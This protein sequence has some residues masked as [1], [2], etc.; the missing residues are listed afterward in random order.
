MRGDSRLRPT[1]QP[2]NG[3]P[4]RAWGQRHCWS[5]LSRSPPGVHPHVRGDSDR[6]RTGIQAGPHGSPPRAWG[7]HIPSVHFHRPLRQGFT[8]TCVGTASVILQDRLPDAHRSPVHPHVRGD[9]VDPDE[10][11]K[12]RAWRF[13]PTCVG[14]ADS[15]IQ[16]GRFTPTCVAS[17][18]VI[19]FT[20]TCVGTAQGPGIQLSAHL[21]FTPTCVGT[22]AMTIG[23]QQRLKHAGSPPRAWGQ[24]YFHNNNYSPDCIGPCCPV[25]SWSG[26]G[27][28]WGIRVNS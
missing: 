28:R 11:G 16:A 24:P 6:G 14:T 7:Q 26:S 25:I 10:A 15:V 19:G 27:A 3:S 17:T 2:A 21:R 5:S 4:P 22:A 1:A 20:P 8:P 18:R 9:S 12:P 23:L 13:T